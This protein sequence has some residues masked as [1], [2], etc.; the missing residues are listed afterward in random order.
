VLAKWE[1][2]ERALT[3]P[4][5]TVPD[6]DESSLFDDLPSGDELVTAGA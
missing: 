3:P 2:L 1:A 6:E 5:A 4:A